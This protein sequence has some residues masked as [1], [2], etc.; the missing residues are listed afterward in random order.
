[1]HIVVEFSRIYIYIECN[2]EEERNM[3]EMNVFGKL[4][5]S[6]ESY[7]GNTI[8]CNVKL[9]TSMNISIFLL[10]NKKIHFTIY[11][12]YTFYVY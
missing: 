8:R 9:E 11:F 4:H 2:L 5:Y 1:M 7:N 10:S 12:F 3:A 6:I